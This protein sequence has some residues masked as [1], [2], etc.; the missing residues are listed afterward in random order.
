MSADVVELT[1]ELV[2]IRTVNP[3]G[4]EEKAASLLA[5]RLEAAGF[6]VASYEFA[7]GRTSLVARL[8]GDGPS[9]CLTGHLDT[10]PLGR[11]DWSVDPFSGETDGDRL[12]G[13]GTSDMKG[14]TAAIVVAEIG[15]AHV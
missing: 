4:D 14:G 6:S 15:R 13:R 2:E 10:V 8:P 1:R 7:P 11:A 5:A 9:L 12:F 3:P